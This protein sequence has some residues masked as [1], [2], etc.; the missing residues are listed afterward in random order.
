MLLVLAASCPLWAQF[1]SSIEGTVSDPSGAVVSN[2]T[3]TLKN[4]ETGVMQA[5][6]TQDS[7]Y[8]RFTSLPSAVFSLTVAAHGFKTTVQEHIRVEVAETKTVNLHLVVGGADAVVEV[9]GEAPSIETSE[10]RVSGEIEEHKIP[11]KLRR[12]LGMHAR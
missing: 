7:G 5:T 6:Q 4:E 12:I 1:T 9:T 2:T 10:G 3:V 11:M 8:F